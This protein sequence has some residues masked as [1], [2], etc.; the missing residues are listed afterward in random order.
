MPFGAAVV[1][2]VL[3]L[4]AGSVPGGYWGMG[5]TALACWAVVGLAWL[6]LL[7]LAIRALP[8]PRRPNLARLWA[9]LAVPLLLIAT[10]LTAR[11]GVT[12]HAAFALHRSSL[13]ALATET[14]ASVEGR[15][16]DRAFLL[17]TVSHSVRDTGTGCV[18]MTVRDAGFLNSTGYAHCPD[19]APANVR[20]GGDGYTFEHLDGP[21][22]VF[23]FQW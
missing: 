1:P 4:W 23:V 12:E 20:A 16:S 14:R 15:A 22:Y 6:V 10:A 8:V 13:E 21:W 3:T 2:V 17:L 11:S 18:L 19:R 7:V 5:L 9:F